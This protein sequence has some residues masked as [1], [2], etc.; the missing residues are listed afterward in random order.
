MSWVAPVLACAGAIVDLWGAFRRSGG[1]TAA[2]GLGWL[3]ILTAAFAVQFG[4]RVGLSVA[5]IPASIAMAGSAALVVVPVT[6]E[7]S[8]VRTIGGTIAACLAIAG[9]GGAIAFEMNVSEAPWPDGA[10][11][12]GAH[13]AALGAA[14]SAAL[15]GASLQI[16]QGIGT[17][18]A[19][20]IAAAA[21]AWGRDC[22]ARAVALVWLAWTLAI[23]VHWRYMGAPGIASRA[24]WFGLG[25]GCLATGGLLL[26]WRLGQGWGAKSRR[27]AASIWVAAVLIAGIW[28]A[29]G[30]GSPF[31]LTLG[32]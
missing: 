5:P 16:G 23:L 18:D 2:A 3:G 14:V 31:Q 7:T 17:D 22:S 11:L 4:P 1:L 8:R 13:W 25:I 28:L 30:F 24:E 10:L 32:A 12:L 29:I 20:E 21:A 26:G 27:I 19:P 6:A 9:A 15:I